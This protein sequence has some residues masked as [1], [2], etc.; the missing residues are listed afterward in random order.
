M[1]SAGKIIAQDMHVD[2]LV[3]V[4]LRS[5]FATRGAIRGRRRAG[6]VQP[7]AGAPLSRAWQALDPAQTV[8]A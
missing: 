4:G 3:Q 6:P 8:D 2:E 1:T 7:V 5:R